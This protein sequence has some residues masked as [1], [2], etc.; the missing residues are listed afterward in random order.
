M[1]DG[2]VFTEYVALTLEA[3]RAA[4]RLTVEQ[5]AEQSG[6]SVRT[7]YRVLHAERD[8]SV[9]QIAAL[10]GVFDMLPSEI[11]AEAQ[12]RMDRAHR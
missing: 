4:A 2:R 1:N 5:L 11:A 7:L 12:R 3:E 10:A 8:I 6:I 9:A